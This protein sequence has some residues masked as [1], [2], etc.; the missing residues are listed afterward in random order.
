[1]FQF[2]PLT[3][4]AAYMS[5][6][7]YCISSVVK[8]F[9]FIN[10]SIRQQIGLQLG[11]RTGRVHLEGKVRLKS[12]AKEGILLEAIDSEKSVKLEARDMAWKE[13]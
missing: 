11:K 10:Q 13:Q 8:N 7:N 12:N 9:Q 3:F 4:E 6:S 2:Y 5:C 1:M